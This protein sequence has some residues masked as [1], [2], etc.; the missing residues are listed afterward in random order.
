MKHKIEELFL[1]MDECVLCPRKCKAHRNKGQKGFCRSADKIFVASRNVHFGEEPPISGQRGS[2]TIFFSNCSLNCVFCQNYPISQLGNGV[3]I[4]QEELS[5]ALISLQDK[6]VCNINFVT[7]T[8]YSA[9]IAKAIF[10][11]RSKGLRVP[12]VY[13]SSGYENPEILKLLEGFIDIYMPDI[14]YSNDVL[15][16]KYSNVKDYVSNNQLSLIEMYRQ[17]GELELDENGIAKRGLLIRHLVLPNN[18]RNSKGALDFIARSISTN[19]FVSLMSQYHGA[20]KSQN[21]PELAD[22]LSKKDYLEVLEYMDKLGFEN[23]WRQ[24]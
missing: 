5:A 13:N 16:S 9:H 8:H 15:A 11:A 14:K 18:T 22:G 7:P 24:I 12:V 23:G 21:F 20:Y 17:V 10:D 4:S 2:G 1:A 6:G 3:E 19:T